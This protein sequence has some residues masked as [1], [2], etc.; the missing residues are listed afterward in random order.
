MNI[1]KHEL[2]ID[3]FCGGGGAS[4]GIFAATGHHPDIAINHSA[5][6]I[7]MHEANHPDT[8]HL[9]ESVWDQPPTDVIQKYGGGRKRVGLMW[10]SPDCTH[11]SKARGSKPVKKEIRG[12]ADVIIKWAAMVRPRQIF[13]E[14]VEEFKTWGPT[15]SAK[16]K[17]G[18]MVEIPDPARKGE[19]FD[20][21]VKD[22]KFQGYDLEWRELKACDYGSP[23]IRKRFFMIARCDGVKIKWPEPTHGPKSTGSD[24]IPYKTAG[25]CID[26]DAPSQSIFDR[27]KPLAPN[28]MARIARGIKKFVLDAKE[29]FIVTCNHGGEGFRGADV[30]EPFKTICGRDAHG[31]VVP[32]IA[33]VPSPVNIVP[34]ISTSAHSKSTGRGKYIYHPCDP[35]RTITGSGGQTVIIPSIARIGQTGFGGDRLAYDIKKPLNTITSKN[36]HLLVSAHI[37]RHFGQGTGHAMDEPASTITAKNKSSLVTAFIAK[38]YGGVT[39]VDI[40]TPFPTITARGTQNNIV[41]AFIS[42]MR[43]TNT[44]HD[45]REPLHTIS[46]GGTHHAEVRAFLLQYY[47]TSEEAGLSK[48]LG[49]V[50]TK[51]R[52]GLVTIS[53]VDYQIVDIHMRMLSPRELARC[54]GFRDDYIL[55]PKYNG[56]PLPK[57]A[58]VKMIGNSVCPQLAEAVISA[59]NKF[60]EKMKEAV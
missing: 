5:P 29:P 19:Y 55:D 3:S 12:L 39:G 38:H 25:E 40:R 57:T 44:G 1:Q 41:T 50:T 8:I 21:W 18:D 49:T 20:R 23:T 54:Q 59:N 31:L 36:E 22:L 48:P 34:F 37:S 32:S 42:K 52:F 33:K 11:F 60:V 45:A 7:A 56:K 2:I 4:E 24:L 35:L 15:I 13:M 30:K 26:W 43:G 9:N 17:A 47:G 46:S 28:T 58:Q 27:K 6:A 16:N 51:D 14:N 53:G 10:A